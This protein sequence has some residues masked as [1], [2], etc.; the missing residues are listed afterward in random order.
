MIKLQT[1]SH[2]DHYAENF[3]HNVRVK[4]IIM[5][6]NFIYNCDHQQ[7]VVWHNKGLNFVSEGVILHVT[8]HNIGVT[9]E[10]EVVNDQPKSIDKLK[11]LS[12]EHFPHQHFKSA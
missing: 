12:P 11:E 7:H 10:S 1:T 9:I 5:N 3:L 2:F 6:P 8:W 4:G